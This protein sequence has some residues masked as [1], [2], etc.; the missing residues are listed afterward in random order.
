MAKWDTAAFNKG[1]RRDIHPETKNARGTRFK[2]E[3]LVAPFW[4][5]S[6][7]LLGIVA[8]I[9][10]NCG[11]K[12]ADYSTFRNDART[13]PVMSGLWCVFSKH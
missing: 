8:Q 9:C 10:L 2:I 6:R 11:K 5:L 12:K 7:L 13:V 3:K 4:S 1:A